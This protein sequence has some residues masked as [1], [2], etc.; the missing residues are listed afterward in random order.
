MTTYYYSIPYSLGPTTGHTTGNTPPIYHQF[1]NGW[2]ICK[3]TAGASYG[4]SFTGAT[5][6]AFGSS[7]VMAG[8]LTAQP[9]YGSSG[10]S[11]PIITH[12]TPVA[13]DQANPSAA[14][15][16]T[17]TQIYNQG[18]FDFTQFSGLIASW[19]FEPGFASSLYFNAP[20]INGVANG[21]GQY[22][23]AA[24]GSVYFVISPYFGG[25]ITN[26]AANLWINETH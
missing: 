1:N 25:S 7:A 24:N 6:T 10:A 18:P 13:L 8:L 14:A 17:L 9:T 2:S 15:T 16:V 12:P 4:F 19:G 3:V 22:N 5:I 26:G 20:S 23:V 11:A 21:V